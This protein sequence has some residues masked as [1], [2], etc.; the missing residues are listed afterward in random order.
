MEKHSFEIWSPQLRNRRGIDVFLPDGYGETLQRHPV[1]YLQD[2]QNLSD[3][4]IAFGGNTWRLE[5]CLRWLSERDIHLATGTGAWETPAEAYRLS[6][7]L[8]ARGVRHALDD[9][10]EQGGHD[11]PYWRHMIWEYLA[12]A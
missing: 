10:G 5:E 12:N 1:V 9:W 6:R 3:P 7:I 4:A 2:G 8:A 11:W